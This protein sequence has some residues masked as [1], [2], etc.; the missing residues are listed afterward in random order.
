MSTI[1]SNPTCE[2][3][4]CNLPAIKFFTTTKKWCCQHNSARCPGVR[5]K[6][7]L[8]NIEKYGTDNPAKSKE[9]KDKITLG[10]TLI[11]KDVVGLKRK[12]T[13]I[14]KYGIDN[15][16]K[17][18]STKN[19]R[20][21][22]F[23]SKY[24]GHPLTNTDVI[25]KRKNTLIEKFG[26]D[27]YGKT[28]EHTLRMTEYYN[29]LSEDVLAD[30]VQKTLHTKFELGIITNPDLKSDF[31][32]YY[33]EVRNLSNRNYKKNKL[34]INPNNFSRGRTSYHLDH[35]F[36]IKDAFENNVPVEVV[37]HRSNLRMLEYDKNIAKGGL[38]EKALSSLFED[39][40]RNK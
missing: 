8:T 7:R 27:N 28:G 40:Y 25:Q 29:T 35:I 10:N 15:I 4:A 33:D 21:E 32:K 22:T 20:L 9:I 2:Y 34:L 1:I 16:S 18:L 17:L 38:S 23:E 13:C 24:G 39:F 26:V 31:E 3:Y 6:T 36:S 5:E 37:S 30:R 12:N 11:D 19:K 14:K